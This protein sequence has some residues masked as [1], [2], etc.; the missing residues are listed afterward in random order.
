MEKLTFYDINKILE[1]IADSRSSNFELTDFI[2]S[3]NRNETT[4]RN[5]VDSKFSEEIEQIGSFKLVQDNENDLE[6]YG[7]IPVKKVFY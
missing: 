3:D 2:D 1:R 6:G 4:L 5:M 7:E